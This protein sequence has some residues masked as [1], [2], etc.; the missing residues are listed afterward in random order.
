MTTIMIDVIAVIAAIAT[1]TAYRA[2]QHELG[3]EEFYYFFHDRMIAYQIEKYLNKQLSNWCGL[4]RAAVIGATVMTLIGE[5]SPLT[6]LV[7]AA[8]T[9]GLGVY[10]CSTVWDIQIN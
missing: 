6:L 7:I 4:S 9:A 1:T 10:A 8:F 3:K 5:L 2:E